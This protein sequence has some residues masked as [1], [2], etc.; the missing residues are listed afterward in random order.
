MR[1]ILPFL[2]L[3][4]SAL[5]SLSVE[6]LKINNPIN[7]AASNTAYVDTKY[8]KRHHHF[9]QQSTPFPHVLQHDEGDCSGHAYPVQRDIYPIC[10]PLLLDGQYFKFNW[11]DVA[12]VKGS[13]QF[14]E[15]DQCKNASFYTAPYNQETCFNT[16][17][18]GPKVRATIW[19]RTG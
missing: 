9:H 13:I 18:R 2:A 7:S 17:K 8:D 14:Y 6:A 4:V 16:E 3:S 15:D 19:N 10:Y 5:P 11:T 12:A 1:V